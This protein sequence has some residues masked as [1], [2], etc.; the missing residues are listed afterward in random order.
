M[1]TELERLREKVSEPPDVETIVQDLIK[2]S[3]SIHVSHL[4][5]PVGAALRKKLCLLL[6]ATKPSTLYAGWEDFGN[7]LN[8]DNPLIQVKLF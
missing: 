4:F 1:D 3:A 2:K 5:S 7:Q 8:L 6:S